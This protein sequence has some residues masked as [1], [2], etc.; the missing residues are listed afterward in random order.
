MLLVVARVEGEGDDV[1]DRVDGEAR[2]DDPGARRREARSM[3]LFVGREADSGDLAQVGVGRVGRNYGARGEEQR[4]NAAGIRL[5]LTEFACF[6]AMLGLTIEFYSTCWS[7][8]PSA[9][10]RMFFPVKDFTEEQRIAG[11]YPYTSAVRVE[12]KFYGAF[13]LN[14]RLSSTP[15]TRRLLDGVS[16]QVPSASRSAPCSRSP[17]RSSTSGCLAGRRR[18]RIPSGSTEG[19][20][21]GVALRNAQRWG[22]SHII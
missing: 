11:T 4:I 5:V 15:S 16:T 8:F 7:Y 9:G 3:R 12:I 18:R 13:V 22:I 21:G 6:C 20:V 19:L 2:E 10:N 1:G 17:S 14:R